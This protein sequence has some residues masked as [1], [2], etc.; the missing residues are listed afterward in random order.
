[1]PASP[2]ILTS[3]YYQWATAFT[4]DFVI[5]QGCENVRC[6][7]CKFRGR[8]VRRGRGEAPPSCPGWTCVDTFQ[9]LALH[10]E[11]NLVE[12]RDHPQLGKGV[13]AKANIPIN[14]LLGEYL[15]VLMPPNRHRDRDDP[16]QFTF[17]T[18]VIGKS[19]GDSRA[20]RWARRADTATTTRGKGVR[21]LDAVHQSS[22]HPERGRRHWNVR[23]KAGRRVQG[24]QEHRPERGD[25]H[26]LRPA[27]LHRDADELHLQRPARAP[28]TPR[29]RARLPILILMTARDGGGRNVFYR[30]HSDSSH[31]DSSN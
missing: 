12:I 18:F 29:D 7:V 9:N 11:V 30:G 16:Y 1:M 4:V 25:H 31:Y 23:A 24:A 21:E 26:T 5:C 28:H 6:V 27:V 13:F 19:P 8:S 17:D 14:Q 20:R 22:L 10:A 3:P 15:G 2:N